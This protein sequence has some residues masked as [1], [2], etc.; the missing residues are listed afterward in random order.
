M[1][2]LTLGTTLLA[3]GDPVHGTYPTADWA[4]GEVVAD[5]YDPRVPLDT[6]PGT[7]PLH[8]ELLASDAETALDAILGQ[9]AVQETGRL[10]VPPTIDHALD[11]TL[12]EQVRLLGYDLDPSQ[13]APEDQLTLTLYWQALTEMEASYTVFTHLLGDDGGVVAQH[14]ASPAGGSYPTT[15]W[16]AGEVVEDPHLLEL[17]ASLAAGT[18]TMEVGMYVLETGARLAVPDSADGAVRFPVVIRSR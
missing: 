2:R 16:V 9:V 12:G 6:A 11:V 17:P 13:P 8:L 5:R 15:L 7:Y 1:V 4:A 10:F 18:Y 14:D 3:E